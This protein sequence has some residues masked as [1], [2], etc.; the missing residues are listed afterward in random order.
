MKIRKTIN[1]EERRLAQEISGKM[2]PSE[3]LVDHMRGFGGSLTRYVA[4]RDLSILSFDMELLANAESGARSTPGLMIV[5]LLEGDGRGYYRPVA[6]G[7]KELT[8]SYKP[9]QTYLFFSEAPVVGR[10]EAHAANR[11]R[12]AEVRVGLDLLK[13]IG[14]LDLFRAAIA[15][16]HPL[17]LASSESGWIGSFP[18][19]NALLS[20]AERLLDRGIAGPDDLIVEARALDILTTAMASM[21]E[22]LFC[23]GARAARSPAKLKAARRLMLEDLARSWTIGELARRVGLTE[24]RLKAEFRAEYGIPVYGFLQRSRLEHARTMLE[25]GR[26]V[27]EVSMAVGYANPSH[28]AKLFRRQFGVRPSSFFRSA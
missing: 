20:D 26:S 12:G 15:T 1:I 5:V 27:T 21:R 18:T 4:R 3:E 24:K 2:T 16:G 28:F 6:A 13:R 19:P 9:K 14:G 17:R 7:G 22:S 8:V 10:Y 23:N 11:F 25:S